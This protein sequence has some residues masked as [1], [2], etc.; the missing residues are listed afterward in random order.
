VISR[1]SARSVKIFRYPMISFLQV[2]S[3]VKAIKFNFAI[4]LCFFHSSSCGKKREIKGYVCMFE[5]LSPDFS[6]N[7]I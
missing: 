1:H 3:V 2:C 6:S 7:K 4:S 5:Y